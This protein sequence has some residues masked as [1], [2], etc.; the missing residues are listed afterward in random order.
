MARTDLEKTQ[1]YTTEAEEICNNLIHYIP[2]DAILVEPFVGDGDLKA[3]FPNHKWLTY[4]IDEST[5]AMYH[6]D[7]LKIKPDYTGK[8]IITNPPYLAKNKAKDKSYFIDS[9]NDDLYKISLASFIGCEG[10]IVIVPLNFLTDEESKDIRK[11]F[12][13][14][15]EILELN[16][17]TQPI[18]KT[19]TYSVCAFAFKKKDNSIQEINTN[20]L[21]EGDNFKYIADKKH[22]YRMAGDF[23][24]L[25]SKEK[26]I[27]GR[28]TDSNEDII[29]NLNLHALDTRSERLH[30]EYSEDHF[31]GKN[32]DRTYLTFTSKREFTEE[33]QKLIASEF[34]ARLNSMRDNYKNLILT[35]YRDWNRKRIGFTFAYKLLSMIVKEL[36]I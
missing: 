34:N 36:N 2:D 5:N 30:I 14:N 1:H 25:V 3:L 21:P 4:D 17:F 12:L 29:L 10:G 15:Y 19:T 11:D 23:F 8:W 9:K 18:F 28:L 31:I 16:V 27:F 22:N 6:Q 20:I 35:N 24:D 26:S 7:T 32:T 33:E 13:S